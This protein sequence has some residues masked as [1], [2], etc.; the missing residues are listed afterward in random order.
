MDLSVI[1]EHGIAVIGIA[2]AA[3]IGVGFVWFMARLIGGRGVGPPLAI[4]AVFLV[5]LGAE[6]AAVDV[7]E[8]REPLETLSL[9]VRNGPK[10]SETVREIVTPEPVIVT[11]EVTVEP[12][13]PAA[14][15]A[16]TEPPA[17][18]EPVPTPEPTPAPTP[19]P[20]PTPTPSVDP[21]SWRDGKHLIINTN[22]S[23]VHCYAD[24][25]SLSR[26]DDSAHIMATGK[27]LAELE[28]EGYKPCG[29]C[30]KR[31]WRR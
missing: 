21:A 12:E 10:Q 19:T 26:S 13:A 31:G 30:D 28:A 27:T 14:P 16:E 2:A 6:V 23:T 17:T 7:L 20:E 4:M 9:P 11:V 8:G 22:T 3:G 1:Y 5:A 29:F 25:Q 24:C 18:P 15:L